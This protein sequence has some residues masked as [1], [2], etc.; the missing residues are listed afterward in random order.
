MNGGSN[1][2]GGELVV[3]P[4]HGGGVLPGVHSPPLGGVT[5]TVFVTAPVG[6]AL[7]VA[8]IV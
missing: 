6:A 4:V 2:F 1:A 5:L 7:T 8:V 3:V